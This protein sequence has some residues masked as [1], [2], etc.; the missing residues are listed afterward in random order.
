MILFRVFLLFFFSYTCLA[1]ENI[2][3]KT[4]QR[5]FCTYGRTV[6]SSNEL[7]DFLNSAKYHHNYFGVCYKNLEIWREE[8]T[9]SFGFHATKE[10]LLKTKTS[11]FQKE[12]NT[13]NSTILSKIPDEDGKI[14]EHLMQETA[15]FD[16][17]E[18]NL[19]TN[20]CGS[21]LGQLVSGSNLS[22]DVKKQILNYDFC[23]NNKGIGKEIIPECHLHIQSYVDS[24]KKEDP[25]E[26]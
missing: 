26:Y 9:T 7:K 15:K 18:F 20:N 11:G 22:T 8:K 21:R 1:T 24:F 6:E 12:P 23:I 2:E 14:Y 16:N 4:E 19:L 13:T 5:Y 3:E 25:P 10:N 17:K